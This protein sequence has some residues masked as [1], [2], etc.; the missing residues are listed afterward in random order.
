M[1]RSGTTFKVVHL[2]H[3]NKYPDFKND[4]EGRASYHSLWYSILIGPVFQLKLLFWSL[5]N[6]KKS[7]R[8]LILLETV[9][10]IMYLSLGVFFRQ[11]FPDLLRFQILAYLGSWIIPLITSY[12]VHRPTEANKLTQTVLYRGIFFRFFAFDHLYHLEHH[13][14][15]GVPHQRWPE[16]AK[17]LNPYFAQTELNF[18]RL[19]LKTKRPLDLN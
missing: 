7:E 3:H 12:L 1:L 5:Q 18:K 13:L 14:Y 19:G 15:P 11:S 6:S 8:N 9:L 2:N 4:P 10:I 17:I 16:L